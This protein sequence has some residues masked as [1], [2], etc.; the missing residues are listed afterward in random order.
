MS[1]RQFSIAV[2]EAL[3]EKIYSSVV[4]ITIWRNV[5][6]HELIQSVDIYKR[7]IIRIP[8]I[9]VTTNIFRKCMNSNFY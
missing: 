9:M 4:L 2:T 5:R 3:I 7:L 6:N 1:G 8:S